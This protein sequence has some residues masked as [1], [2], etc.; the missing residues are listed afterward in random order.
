MK[1]LTNVIE[2]LMNGLSK[3]AYKACGTRE[4]GEKWI[5]TNGKT[6]IKN[7]LSD[8]EAADRFKNQFTPRC[9]EV[10]PRC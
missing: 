4:S 1:F 2:S 9:N 5:L 10:A 6:G 3:N 7:D 8:C